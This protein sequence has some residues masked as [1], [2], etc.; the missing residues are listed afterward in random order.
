MAIHR[1][2]CKQYQNSRD[3]NATEDHWFAKERYN[4]IKILE[5]RDQLQVANLSAEIKEYRNK[6]KHL[7]R[8]STERIPR[9]RPMYG[10]RLQ[11]RCSL[12]RPKKEM[13]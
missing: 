6:L 5:I 2:K 7:Q 1:N 3:E 9:C 10:Y 13:E 12:G 4:C 8:M 11:G